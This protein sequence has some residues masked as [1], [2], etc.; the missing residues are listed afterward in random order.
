M[1]EIDDIRACNEVFSV[2]NMPY[3]LMA[4]LARLLLEGHAWQG[5]EVLDRGAAA[6]PNL[7][8]PPLMEAHRASDDLAAL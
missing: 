4:T 8:K 5:S 1:Q 2:G 7:P 6:K 3:I